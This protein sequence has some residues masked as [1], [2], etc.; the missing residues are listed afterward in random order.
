M[1]F[2]AYILITILFLTT[3]Y[4]FSNHILSYFVEIQNWIKFYALC[5]YAL[6][7]SLE[8][9]YVSSQ[10]DHD[11]IRD[12]EC[13]IECAILAFNDAHPNSLRMCTTCYN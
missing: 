13:H 2:Y 4:A 5:F 8:M 1:L 7:R 6:F 3:N 11:A 10:R 12:F 9:T